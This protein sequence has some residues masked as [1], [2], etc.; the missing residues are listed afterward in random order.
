MSQKP[1]GYI[2]KQKVQSYM[3]NWYAER[4]S[5][6]TIPGKA[7]CKIVGYTLSIAS[8]GKTSVSPML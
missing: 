4:T 1:V 5:S 2:P 3:K 8:E 6:H 7:T